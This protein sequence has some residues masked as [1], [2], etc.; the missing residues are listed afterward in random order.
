M[1]L[2]AGSLRAQ[3]K[4]L[5]RNL[6]NLYLKIKIDFNANPVKPCLHLIKHLLK[7]ENSLNNEVIITILYYMLY[8]IFNILDFIH[9]FLTLYCL[10]V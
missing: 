8:S 5:S 7:T 3:I 1:V 10:I 4:F 6:R 2:S 9:N